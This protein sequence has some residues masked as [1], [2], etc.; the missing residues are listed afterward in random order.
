VL[1]LVAFLFLVHAFAGAARWPLTVHRDAYA[2]GAGGPIAVLAAAWFAIATVVSPGTASP[3]AYVPIFNPLE[4][5]L[6]LTLVALFLWS[7]RFSGLRDTTRFAWLGVGLFGLL[8]GT[9]LRTA[10][11]WG[12]IP[13]QLNA[14]LA[15][16]LLQAGLTLAWTAT[17]VVLMFFA[18]RRALRPLWMTGA[19]LLA[20][21]IGKL[22]LIDLGTLSGLP[23]VVAFL[24]VGTL[25][26][27]IGYLSPLPPAA[28]NATHRDPA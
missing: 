12:A 8:N 18:T 15:S 22:F 16:K 1:P 10:H 27:L 5:T 21:S 25:L 26:L 2:I 4:L 23:R 19:G 14:L 3:L 9:A 11:H 6:V 13:W 17:A 7:G 28:Q 24:G 20:L